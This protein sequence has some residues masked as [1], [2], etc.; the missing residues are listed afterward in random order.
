MSVLDVDSVALRARFRTLSDH[1]R[2]RLQDF[3][4]RLSVPLNEDTFPVILE[5]WRTWYPERHEATPER[6]A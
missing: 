5:T 3:A 6:F 4:D 1:E 2:A